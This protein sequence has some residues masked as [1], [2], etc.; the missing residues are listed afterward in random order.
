ME[1]TIEVCS[2]CG[3][4]PRAID[5]TTGFFNCTRCGNNKLISV[6]ADDYERIVIELDSNYQKKVALIR[7]ES[8]E[9]EMPIG[10]PKKKSSKIKKVVAKKKPVKKKSTAKKKTKA[11]GKKTSKKKKK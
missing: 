6:K 10:N 2:K 1:D 7:R 9:K 11:T 4:M 5:Q 8:I 3:K